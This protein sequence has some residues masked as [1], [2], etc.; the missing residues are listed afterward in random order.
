VDV[1]TIRY[2]EK[3]G[4]LPPPARRDNGYRS[5]GAP[6]L[7][8]LTFIR[9]CRALDISLAE[10]KRLLDF[11]DQPSAECGDV[12]RLIDAQLIRVRTRIESLCALERQLTVLRSCCA[13]PHTAADCGILRELVGAK[14]P[15]NAAK[16]RPSRLAVRFHLAGTAATMRFAP[17]WS[18]AAAL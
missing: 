8:R 16:T 7:E 10:I 5:Y 15:R 17:S 14:P 9:H 13:I 4:L 11:L 6:H 18:L 1:E 2:Y 12:D 3:Y